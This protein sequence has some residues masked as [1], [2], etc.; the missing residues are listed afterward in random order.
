MLVCPQC[1]R[2]RPIGKQNKSTTIRRV[3]ILPLGEFERS[4]KNR[5]FMCFVSA[6]A[7]DAPIQRINI[8]IA[9]VLGF[10]TI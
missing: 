10:F 3:S 8:V 1:F 4:A 7:V 9:V 2:L 5:W 6:E